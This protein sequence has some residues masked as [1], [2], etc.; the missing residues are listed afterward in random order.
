[1]GASN[2]DINRLVSLIVETQKYFFIQTQ[3]QVNTAITLR[4]YFYWLIYS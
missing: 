4:N 1:M 2:I 3:K